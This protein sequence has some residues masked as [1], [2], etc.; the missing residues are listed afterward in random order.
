MGR[1]YSR[2]PGNECPVEFASVGPEDRGQIGRIRIRSTN[3]NGQP[4]VSDVWWQRCPWC[5]ELVEIDVARLHVVAGLIRIDDPVV[6][7]HCEILYTVDAGV[8]TKLDVEGA[9][10]PAVTSKAFNATREGD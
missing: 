5:R 9:G 2:L 1:I 3:G 8:A 4:A 7:S 10:H 6:C